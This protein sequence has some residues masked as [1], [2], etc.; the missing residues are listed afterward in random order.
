MF[1]EKYGGA[2]HWLAWLGI[3]GTSELN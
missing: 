3:G 1:F 2:R